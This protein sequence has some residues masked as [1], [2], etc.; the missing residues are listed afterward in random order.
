MNAEELFRQWPGVDKANADRFLDSPAWVLRTPYAGEE[1]VIVADRTPSASDWLELDITLDGE[2][3]QLGLADTESFSDL[4]LLWSRREA[5]PPEVLLALIEKECGA[6]LQCLENAFR[7]E[8]SLKRVCGPL[9]E[10]LARRC[11]RLTGPGADI[12]FAL[13]L[14]PTMALAWGRARNIDTGH[15]A[16]RAMTRPVW[17]EYAALDLIADE[18]SRLTTGG[19]LALPDGAEG[20]WRTEIASDDLVHVYAAEASSVTFAEMADDAWPAVLA[21]ESAP[22]VLVRNGKQFAN[23]VCTQIGARRFVKIV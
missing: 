19:A 21:A 22:L 20:A 4:H 23:G 14:S 8:V 15:E 6:F 13:D 18:V 5:L 3:H 2:P 16:V 10:D 1:A 17:A 12:S 9:T 7:Q 11:F